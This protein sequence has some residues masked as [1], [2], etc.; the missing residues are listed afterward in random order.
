MDRQDEGSGVDRD[1][2]VCLFLL[3]LKTLNRY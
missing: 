1:G 2:S 3:Q